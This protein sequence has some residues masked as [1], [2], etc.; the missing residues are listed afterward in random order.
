MDFDSIQHKFHEV[1]KQQPYS[2]VESFD[3][4]TRMISAILETDGVNWVLKMKKANGEL[5]LTNT[6]RINLTN[7]MENHIDWILRFFRPVQK[8]GEPQIV[9]PTV[10]TE[11]DTLIQKI[12][13]KPLDSSNK[14]MNE[15]ILNLETLKTKTKPQETI[16]LIQ[17]DFEQLKPLIN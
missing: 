5:L 17:K 15:L 10:I 4:I 7:A 9:S 8:G 16:V 12:N 2:W 1:M 3:G 6:E 11:I 14:T 13:E